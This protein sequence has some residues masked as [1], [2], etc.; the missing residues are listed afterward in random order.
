VTLIA[1]WRLSDSIVIH[2]DSQETVTGDDGIEYRKTVLKIESEQMGNYKVIVAGSGDTPFILEFI[3]KL[4][5]RLSEE[6]ADSLAA[7]IGIFE[8]QLRAHMDANPNAERSQFIVGLC[9]PISNEYNAWITQGS[10]LCPFDDHELTGHGESLY[11]ETMNR[12]W[13]PGMT[14]QQAILAGIYLLTLAE[15][16]SNYVRSPFNIAI[17][18]GNGIWT[19]PQKYIQLMRD[20]LSEYEQWV[21]KVFLACADTSINASQ[22]KELL[23]NFSRAA[24]NLH[25]QHIDRTVETL[26]LEEIMATDDPYPRRPPGI[27]TIFADGTGKFIHDPERTKAI[28]SRFRDAMEYAVKAPH[29]LRCHQC[30]REYEYMLAN[31]GQDKEP[32]TIRCID[33][34]AVNQVIG[35]VSKIQRLSS[36]G[37]VNLDETTP[38]STS[39]KSEP[40]Q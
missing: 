13:T 18:R 6:S 15:A 31:P 39:G 3:E 8:E 36:P 34:N 37:W 26:T 22:L 7:F 9:C 19:E 1:A 25:E 40:E 30:E 14:I 38:P 17:I 20:R 33:C 32:A 28:E 5:R 2:A 24:E 35:K 23:D 10:T 16:T 27:T 4:R 11:K 21:S 29:Y 12:F